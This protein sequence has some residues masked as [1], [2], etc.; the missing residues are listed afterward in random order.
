MEWGPES[1][2]CYL[3]SR[4]NH[5]ACCLTLPPHP[6]PFFISP[7]DLPD[8]TRFSGTVDAS[9]EYGYTVTISLPNNRQVH[10]TLF[11]DPFQFPPP[12]MRRLNGEDTAMSGGA[13][14]Q[15]PPDVQR[16]SLGMRLPRPAKTPYQFFQMG[17]SKEQLLQLHKLPVNN[18]Y[19]PTTEL[20]QSLTADLWRQ[21]TQDQLR[22][23]VDMANKDRNRF[24]QEWRDYRARCQ[25]A[26]SA[27]PPHRAA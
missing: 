5:R 11:K 2:G 24:E 18:D 26:L 13:E 7:Q 22:P 15:R 27:C 23:F 6:N 10:A 1:W 17:V 19:P 25:E 21:M 9:T 20:L 3:H 16:N 12:G 4:A 14:V 8:G